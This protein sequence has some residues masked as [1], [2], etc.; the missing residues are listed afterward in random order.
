MGKLIEFYGDHEHEHE[1]QS[2]NTR[3]FENLRMTIS[4]NDES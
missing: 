2:P 4:T 1:R 3:S